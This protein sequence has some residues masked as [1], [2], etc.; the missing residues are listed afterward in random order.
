M[1]S[2]GIKTADTVVLG[3]QPVGTSDAESDAHVLAALLQVRKPMAPPA[4]SSA[5]ASLR[6]PLA[7]V[8]AGG[9]C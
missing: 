9:T 4:A 6:L 2:A 8:V 7:A 5:L 1:L 3:E